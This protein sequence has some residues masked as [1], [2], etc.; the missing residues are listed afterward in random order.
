[1]LTGHDTVVAD[2]IVDGS[3]RICRPTELSRTVDSGGAVPSVSV[4]PA[5]GPAPA[6]NTTPPAPEVTACVNVMRDPGATGTLPKS[7]TDLLKPV[8]IV[9]VTLA[10]PSTVPVER[11]QP[12]GEG[13]RAVA[14]DCRGVRERDRPE[15]RAGV[16]VDVE[17]AVDAVTAARER[18]VDRDGG[19]EGGGGEGGGQRRGGKEGKYAG[20][21]GDSRSA[22]DSPREC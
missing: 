8:V 20:A 16:I 18:A 4:T 17:A 2:A 14:V 22:D 15:G 1:V 5:Q 10:T 12:R 7:N 6:S 21:H 19:G 11:R 13:D 9:R 3:P